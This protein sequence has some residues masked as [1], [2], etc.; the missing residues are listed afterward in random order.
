MYIFFI[1][2]CSRSRWNDFTPFLFLFEILNF[3]IL[4][5]VSNQKEMLLMYLSLVDDDLRTRLRD[6]APL[7]RRIRGG[8]RLLQVDEILTAVLNIWEIRT[9]VE[10]FSQDNFS[11]F[12]KFNRGRVEENPNFIHHDTLPLL[13]LF[14]RGSLPKLSEHCPQFL[15]ERNF[16]TQENILSDYKIK[17]ILIKRLSDDKLSAKIDLFSDNFE[18]ELKIS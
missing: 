6:H 12:E 3:H 1:H 8:G 16:C 7:Q 2:L 14:V 11:L 5:T 9:L 13:E 17:G 4:S 10:V 15:K 18:V